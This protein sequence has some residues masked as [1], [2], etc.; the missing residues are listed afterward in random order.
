[1]NNVARKAKITETV[2]RMMHPGKG[3]GVGFSD[4]V[5]LPDGD[6]EG[7]S[8]MENWD[9]LKNRFKGTAFATGSKSR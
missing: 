4:S 5:L 9:W 2:T 6:E 1:M 8:D 7:V 3:D